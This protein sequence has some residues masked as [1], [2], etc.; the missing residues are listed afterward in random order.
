MTDSIFTDLPPFPYPP[1]PAVTSCSTYLNGTNLTVSCDFNNGSY[2]VLVQFAENLMLLTGETQDGS[3]VEFKNLSSS[4]LN[5]VV[6]PL[7][8]NGIVGT[9]VAF[10]E[11][12]SPDSTDPPVPTS[13]TT[14]STSPGITTTSP[15]S[16][17]ATSKFKSFI[18]IFSYSLAGTG[19]GSNGGRSLQ[20]LGTGAVAAIVGEYAHAGHIVSLCITPYSC[21]L[22]GDSLIPVT[23]P[24]HIVL[25]VHQQTEQTQNVQVGNH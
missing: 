1:V 14:V 19:N 23:S 13:V 21:A 24:R 3:P 18:D 16:T 20:G 5:V 15:A 25:L 4:N 10:T 11:Q 2:Y 6:F 7:T 12:V 17:S 9:T 8:E 22:A